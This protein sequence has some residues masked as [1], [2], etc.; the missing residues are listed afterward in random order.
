MDRYFKEVSVVPPTTC[1]SKPSDY[2]NQ[3]NGEEQQVSYAYLS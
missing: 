2:K 1:I 3:V